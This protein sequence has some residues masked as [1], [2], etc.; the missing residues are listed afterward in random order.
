MWKTK[1]LEIFEK[2]SFVKNV[3]DKYKIVSIILW[4]LV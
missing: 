3:L 2:Y 4:N 1:W